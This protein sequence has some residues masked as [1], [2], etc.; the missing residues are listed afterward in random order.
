MTRRNRNQRSRKNRNQSNRQRNRRGSGLFGEKT[1]FDNKMNCKLYWHPSTTFNPTATSEC[2]KN[3]P[4]T[5]IPM[6][7]FINY[8]GALKKTA[9]LRPTYKMN[10]YPHSAGKI[11][12]IY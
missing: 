10:K 6:Y 7:K 8:P 4:G 11:A 12:E 3:Y 1:E 9:G 2:D 5:G